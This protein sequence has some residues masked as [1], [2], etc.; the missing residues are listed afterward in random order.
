MENIKSIMAD[1][2]AHPSLIPTPLSVDEDPDGGEPGCLGCGGAGFVHPYGNGKVDYSRVIP[3][4]CVQSKLEQRRNEA[5]FKQCELPEFA[6]TMTFETYKRTP[7][8]EDA[9]TASL[10]VAKGELK[11]LTLSGE[12]D[13]GKTHLAVS[14]CRERLKQGQPA[15]YA[16]VPLLLDELKAGFEQDG[17]YQKRFDFF[18][19]VPL[20]VLDD[21]GTEKSTGWAQEKLDTIVDYRAMHGLDLVVTTNLSVNQLPVRIASRLLRAK[22]SQVVNLTGCEYRLRGVAKGGEK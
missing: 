2:K 18:C 12:T 6:S 13:L 22:D 7:Q 3:C 9:F 11:W 15:R 20:L 19:Q 5:Y 4:K 8:L 1:L 14:I 21:L 16:Y 17:E 10:K